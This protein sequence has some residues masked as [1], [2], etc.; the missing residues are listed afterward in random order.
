FALAG[1]PLFP[2]FTTPRTLTFDA[3]QVN[4]NQDTLYFGVSNELPAFD[5]EADMYSEVAGFPCNDV[6]A[7]YLCV[8]N[9]S[10]V[11]ID[12]QL[13]FH[14][15][16]LFQDITLSPLIDSLGENVAYLSFTDVT[17]YELICAEVELLS[18]TLE[19]IGAYLETSM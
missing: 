3:T 7:S 9:T 1:N 5:L 19:F 15:D 12:V 2:F 18:P 10:N 17:S 16:S 14:Y 8:R 6:T 4:W 11:P 13:E